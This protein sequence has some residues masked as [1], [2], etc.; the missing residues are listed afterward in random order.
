M[1]S[2][3]NSESRLKMTDATEMP[4]YDGME[5]EELVAAAQYMWMENAKLRNAVEYLYGFAK[6]LGVSGDDLRE[7]FG[8]EVTDA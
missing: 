6:T 1:R 8:I 3:R 5:Y 2:A 4:Q 7:E